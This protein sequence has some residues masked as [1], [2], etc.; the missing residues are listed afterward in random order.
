MSERQL[1]VDE[2]DICVYT[3]RIR[4]APRFNISHLQL[5]VCQISHSHPC[6]E[7]RHLRAFLSFFLSSH[8]PCTY[9]YQSIDSPTQGTVVVILGVIGIVAFGSINS[10]LGT[11]TDAAHLTHLWTRT[12][13]LLFFFFMAFALVFLY[14]FVSQL[15]I[16]LAARSDL[17]AL[18]SIPGGSF[19]LGR[20]TTFGVR[21][22]RRWERLMVA[23]RER[24]E[25]WTASHDDKRVAWTLGI[26]WACCGGGLAGGTLVFAKAACVFIFFFL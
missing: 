8:F 12:N 3:C 25:V 4:C 1:S 13:W 15:D 23:V 24:L 16:V 7:Q 10:G 2:V 26:G 19:A 6:H 21:M 22:A 14:I 9:A 5:H 20:G 17:S 18:S 11:A